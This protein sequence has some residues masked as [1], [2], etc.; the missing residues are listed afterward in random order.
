LTSIELSTRSAKE[1]RM[2]RTGVAAA[3][4]AAA[5]TVT[6]ASV[7]VAGP[8]ATKQRVAINMKF[9]TKTFV[10]T[11]L[12]AGDLRR[13]SGTVVQS[14]HSACHNVIRY[15]LKN[16]VCT[17]TL[18]LTGE[19]GTLTVRGPVEWRDGGSPRTCGVAFGT[20]KVV[21]GTDEYTGVTG[22]GVSAYDAHCS[23]WYARYEGFLTAS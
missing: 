17:D 12:S 15:G 6:L 2:T 13:D 10:F 4:L 9:H 1:E 11:P 14:G 8:A 5:V 22:A 3:A 19:R 21:R 20:W 23:V 7:A 18:T 16:E